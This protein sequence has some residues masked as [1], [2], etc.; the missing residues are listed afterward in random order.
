MQ[1][2]TTQD[3]VYKILLSRQDD[4]IRNDKSPKLNEIWL[5]SYDG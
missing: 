3:Q 4:S 1:S 5:F 2:R